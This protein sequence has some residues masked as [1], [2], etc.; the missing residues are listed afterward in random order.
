LAQKVKPLQD[1]PTATG[2]TGVGL[3]GLPVVG[4]GPGGSWV[5][6]AA[7]I[8]SNAPSGDGTGTAVTGLAAV[9]LGLSAAGVSVLNAT[10][11]GVEATTVVNP[12]NVEGLL[13]R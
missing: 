7:A 13:L 1:C 3:V 4:K 11:I 8:V 5:L 6:D 9:T 2:G 12:P 10:L